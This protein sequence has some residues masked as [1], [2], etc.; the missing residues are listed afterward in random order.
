MKITRSWDQ[1]MTHHNHFLPLRPSIFPLPP[2]PFK[3]SIH[4]SILLSLPPSSSFS[5]SK[6]FLNL[7]LC[8][9]TFYSPLPSFFSF[10]L[11]SLTPAH[12]FFFLSFSVPYLTFPPSSTPFYPIPTLI[13]LPPPSLSP[14]LCST[15]TPHPISSPPTPHNHR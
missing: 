4:L 15:L 1:N 14:S 7:I 9:F 8:Y 12:C 10:T 13:P 11:P 5:L 2:R 6:H 3:P